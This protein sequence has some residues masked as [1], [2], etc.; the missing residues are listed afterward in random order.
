MTTRDYYDLIYLLATV[1]FIFGLK[2]LSSPST[3]R[4]GN[5]LGM[6]GMA[7][8]MGGALFDPTVTDYTWV[9]GGLVIGGAIGLVMA[10]RV[11]MTGMPEMVALFNGFGGLASVLVG[12]SAHESAHVAAGGAVQ[13][14]AQAVAQAAGEAPREP[15][16]EIALAVFIGAITFTGSL[17]AMGKLQGSFVK[18][19]PITFPAQHAVNALLAA[20]MLALGAWFW[21]GGP[22]IALWAML[23]IALLLGILLVIPIGGADMPVVV[24]LLN[25]YSGWAAGMTGFLLN[26]TVLIVTGALVGASG[27]ILSYIMCKAMNR[28]FSNVL[29][30]GFGATGNEEAGPDLAGKSVKQAAVEDA[31]YMMG[32]ASSVIIVPGYGMAVAQ[33]Q[34]AVHELGEILEERGVTTRYAIHPVAGRMPGHMNVLLAEANVPYDRVQPLDEINS[35][36]QTTDVVLVVGAN[37][38]VNPAAVTNTTSPIYGMPI[39]DAYKARMVYCIKRSMRPGYAGVENELYYA[40]NCMMVFGDAKDVCERLVSSVKKS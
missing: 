38:I 30:G 25:S 16:L 13:T 6:A 7:I 36:F 39:L 32:N 19:A 8:A 24:A 29:L 2:G 22:G 5:F 9:V 28:S 23:A 33:A 11:K 34:H 15:T 18:S 40:D 4:R 3:A 17:I 27:T 21:L 14:A 37:D 10:H 12:V 35:D 20:A 31:A 1:L 26:N